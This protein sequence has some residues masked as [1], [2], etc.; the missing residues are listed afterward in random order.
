VQAHASPCNAC[1]RENPWQANPADM[2]P[3]RT[4]PRPKH[5]ARKTR[6]PMPRPVSAQAIHD[7]IG[8]SGKYLPWNCQVLFNRSISDDMTVRAARLVQKRWRST[9]DKTP[10]DGIG[11]GIAG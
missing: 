5:L 3:Q 1:R 2:V 9:K 11:W 7:C 6:A 10:P 8:M 4:D